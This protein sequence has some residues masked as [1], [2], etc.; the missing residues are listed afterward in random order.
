MKY[1]DKHIACFKPL[2]DQMKRLGIE[3]DYLPI[4]PHNLNFDISKMPKSH[5]VLIYMPKGFENYYGYDEISR[6]FPLFPELKF[7]IVANDDKSKFDFN[8]VEVLGYL[9][10]EEMEKL[11][12]E[13]SIV[14][15]IHINDGLSMSVLEGLAKGKRV[16]WNYEFSFCLP[17]TTTEEISNSINEIISSNPI[18]VADEAAHEYIINDFSRERF[19]TLFN[20][21]INDVISRK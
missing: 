19:M 20:K 6:V 7:F 4:I 11:Y 2:Q 14:V 12:N 13:I 5:S 10:L 9:K 16:I 8:N 3:T 21:I 15:R 1:F 18:P 17:G